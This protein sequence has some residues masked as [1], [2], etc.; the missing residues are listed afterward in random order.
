MFEDFEERRIDTGETE[1]FLR[2]GG[3]GP[4]LLLL[5]GYPQ[6]HACWHRVA[7]ILA[8]HHTVICP[9]LRG[10]GR[11][12]CPESDP[13]HEVYAKRAV[14][15]DQVRVMQAL[16]FERFDLCGH[17]RGGRVAH[18]LARDWP[19]NVRRLA[20]LD[21]MPTWETWEQYDRKAAMASYHWQF[22]AQPYDLP[23]R[24]V[25]HEP[26]YYLTW[27][28]NSWAASEQFWSEEAYQD[29]LAAI[30]QPERFHAMCED[31]RA[32]AGLDLEH[33]AA[34]RDR[35][36]AMPLLVLWGGGH[37]RKDHWP[38]VEVWREN[39]EQVE[40]RP[41]P[42]GHFL[43]EE[44]PDDTAAALAAFFTPDAEDS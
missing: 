30:R 19:A 28:L 15:R 40:G 25:A 26:D 35:K 11:S 37:G 39:A 14:A 42:C 21:I 22:L 18:R 38:F 6:S 12:G 16:G 2:I 27:T 8:E 24:L 43:P 23:E 44:A 7:P 36:L 9:D 3:S 5:H 29:Y 32:G 17:D 20:L 13:A 1:I 4:P 41:L 34:D 33:D 10:Y 31:Y